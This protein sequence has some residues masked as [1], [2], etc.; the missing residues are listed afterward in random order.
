MKYRITYTTEVEWT[1]EEVK[2][3]GGLEN[4]VEETIDQD[5]S[6]HSDE[7]NWEVEEIPLS[8]SETI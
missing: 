5:S 6:E 4:A 8:Y 1:E 7:S 2:A 3:I